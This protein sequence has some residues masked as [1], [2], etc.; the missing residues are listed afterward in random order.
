MSFRFTTFKIFK[1]F[2]NSYFHDPYTSQTQDFHKEYD[3]MTNEE[4]NN[5]DMAL[6]I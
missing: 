2:E 5:A 1:P 4:D 3:E 6:E